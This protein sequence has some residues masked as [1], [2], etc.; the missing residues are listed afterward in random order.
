[1]IQF[2]SNNVANLYHLTT[3]S[4]TCCPTKWTSCCDHSCDVTSP[5]VL[6]FDV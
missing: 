6:W 5:Y 1:M 2:Y 3:H 4:T